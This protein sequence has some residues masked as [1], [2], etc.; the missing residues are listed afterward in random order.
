[1]VQIFS[2][3]Q[4]LSQ[5]HYPRNDFP[6]VQFLKAQLPTSILAA[7]LGPPSLLQLWRYA[8]QTILVLALSPYC[9]G[10]PNL[11]FVKFPLGKLHIQ[12]VV[13]WKIDTWEVALKEM[14]LGT[15][16]TPF[17]SRFDKETTDKNGELLTRKTSIM[18]GTVVNRACPSSNLGLIKNMDS[19]FNGIVIIILFYFF[20]S[21]I[22]KFPLKN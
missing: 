10:G 9:L 14:P 16:L 11:I 17:S 20:N 18:V 12:E 19:P 21:T 15:Y 1:M 5:K 22:K 3:C 13:T 4:V 2:R 6:N 8:P 7:A